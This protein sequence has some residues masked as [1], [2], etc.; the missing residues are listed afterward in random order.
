MTYQLYNASSKATTDITKLEALTNNVDR[1]TDIAK[2]AVNDFYKAVQVVNH[3][4]QNKNKAKHHL[5]INSQSKV[6]SALL[7]GKVNKDSIKNDAIDVNPTT[8]QYKVIFNTI[9]TKHLKNSSFYGFSNTVARNPDDDENLLASRSAIKDFTTHFDSTYGGVSLRLETIGTINLYSSGNNYNN[10]YYSGTTSVSTSGA[11]ITVTSG[12]SA[13]NRYDD[14]F[15]NN[16]TAIQANYNQGTNAGT[17]WFNSI[18]GMT[19]HSSNSTFL[20]GIRMGVISFKGFTTTSPYTH[21][22]VRVPTFALT[23]SQLTTVGTGL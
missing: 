3:L 5:V 11:D 17:G 22:T 8:G 4:I 13:Q 18:R 20:T 6:P 16:E 21:H 7:I 12:V 10:S 2:K 23:F 19:Q 14:F 15:R 9:E 1:N